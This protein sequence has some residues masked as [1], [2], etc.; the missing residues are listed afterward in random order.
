MPSSHTPV[1]AVD[2][3]FTLGALAD[4]ALERAAGVLREHGLVQLG[5]LGGRDDVL[6][7]AGRFMAEPWQHRDA[8]PDGLTV[9]RDTGRHEGLAGFAGLGRGDL[10]L[11]TECA[12]LPRPPRLLLLACA[13]TADSGGETL[14]VDGRAVLAELAGFHPTSLEAL[15]APRAAY[16]GGADGHFAPVLEHLPDGRWRLRLRQDSL[17]RFSPDAE[18]HLPALRRAV[19]H[20]T[21]RTRLASGQGLVL[22]NHRVLHGRT[23]FV[24]ARLLLRALGEPRA[25]LGLDSGFPAPWTAPRL[26]PAGDG[27]DIAT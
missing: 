18:A 3:E 20:N 24:G 2:E 7:A 6:E 22:D 21:T 14:L 8:D 16:F 15:A 4:G 13:R 10:S 12:Q 19:E 23:A 17:A 9:V 27:V 1:P 25:V 26:A 11:H 5:R